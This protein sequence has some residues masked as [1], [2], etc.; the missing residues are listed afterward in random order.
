MEWAIIHV[1]IGDINFFDIDYN[2]YGQ[3]LPRTWIRSL[4]QFVHEYK[5]HLPEYEY[6]IKKKRDGDKFLMQAFHQAGYSK[7]KLLQLNR[8][9]LYLQVETLSDITDGTGNQISI[10][11]YQG[12]KYHHRTSLHDWPEQPS[13]DARH[14]K[15]WRQALRKSF[16]RLTTQRTGILTTSLGPWIDGE[17][18]KW[19]WFVSIVSSRMYH[20]TST[21]PEW[22]IYKRVHHHGQ[23]NKMN[24]F[25]FE[26]Y[27]NNLPMD[28]LRATVIIDRTNTNRYRITGWAPDNIII[29]PTQD[30]QEQD[31]QLWMIDQKYNQQEEAWIADQLRLNHKIMI[32]SDGSYH[33]EH[34]IGT[35]AW[36]ITTENDTSN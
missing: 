32:V 30:Q 29:Q 20:R 12:Q 23:L 3:L 6:K 16:S 27:T 33:P 7:K 10:P 24:Q 36:V 2:A 14:W 28:A 4:W 8:C 35:S 31:K 21:N 22:K 1:G 15:L 18:D 5:I 11:S 34:E 9:R 19:T 25:A 13:P 26:G 17:K